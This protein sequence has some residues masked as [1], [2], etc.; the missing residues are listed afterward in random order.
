MIPSYAL[1]LWVNRILK[2]VV[3]TIM[4]GGMAVMMVIALVAL[5]G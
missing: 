3:L 5:L 4:L 1:I 2:G